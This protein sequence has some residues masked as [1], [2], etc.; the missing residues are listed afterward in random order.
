MV[1][2]VE[3]H[4][5]RS[6]G[7]CV[8]GVDYFTPN[9]SLEFGV[10]PAILDSIA[11]TL[12]DEISNFEEVDIKRR[13]RQTDPEIERQ[14]AQSL[15]DFHTEIVARRCQEGLVFKDL[16]TP[17]GL[18]S[19]FRNKGYWF[20][21][22][23]DYN[24]SGNAAD[25]DVLVLG[26]CF[27]TGMKKARLLNRFLVGCR[28][29]SSDEFM[30]ICTV[31]GGGT[32][33]E[34]LE[35]LLRSTGFKVGGTIGE[36]DVGNWFKSDKLPDFIS[37]KSY[38]RSMNSDNNGW[39][40]RRD[41]FPDLWIDPKDS[42][43]LTINAG[44]IVSSTD[45]SAGVSLRFPRISRIRAKNFD[46]PKSASDVE[47]ISFIHERYFQKQSQMQ[48]AE[49]EAS[50]SVPQRNIGAACK[51]L[52]SEQHSRK[53]SIAKKRKARRN[54]CIRAPNMSS[55]SKAETRLF[56]N[57]NFNVCFRGQLQFGIMQS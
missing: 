10:H 33:T 27:A 22:K 39:K 44:E 28:E 25:I 57:Y 53:Q 50:L 24:Q 11:C 5:I 41:H 46:D 12:D 47:T 52:T 20:K 40:Y 34:N 45:H 21:L 35:R 19:R 51:F 38:Q 1:E 18:G 54:D 43:V 7:T 36:D 23:D 16:A 2:I 13:R 56:S 37:Q 15:E 17:Y 6:D 31:N 29:D 55:S 30:T 26:A 48:T 14:R 8:D 9:R 42:F 3:S 49:R 32:S 4:V